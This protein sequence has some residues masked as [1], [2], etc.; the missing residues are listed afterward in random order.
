MV[1]TFVE[2]AFAV[3]DIK[4]TWSGEGVEE[5]GKDEAGVVRVR[6]SPKVRTMTHR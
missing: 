6:V 5:V 3:V 2:R 4:I 1:R